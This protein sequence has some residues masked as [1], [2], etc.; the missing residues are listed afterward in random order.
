MTAL[1]EMAMRQPDPRPCGNFESTLGSMPRSLPASDLGVGQTLL[2]HTSSPAGK[3]CWHRLIE[4]CT[5]ND[6]LR[7]NKQNQSIFEGLPGHE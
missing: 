1:L 3:S 4:F 5:N 2:G 7:I 6:Q